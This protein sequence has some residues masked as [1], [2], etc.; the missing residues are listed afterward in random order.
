[1]IRATQPATI[2]SVILKAG[3]LTYETIRYGILSKSSE[4]RKE[5]AESSKQGGSW[6]D[7]KRSKLGKG[8]VATV[9]TMNEYAGIYP[10]CAKCNAHHP[11]SVPCLLFY[12]SPGQAGNRLTIKGNQN[13]RV[14]GNQA[15]GMAFNMKTIEARHD[16]NVVT[17]TFSVN[18]HFAII[19][20]DSGADFSS[21]S[22]DFVSL[23]NEKPSILRPSYVIGITNDRK[24]ESNMIIHGCKLELVDSLF[25]IDLI[26]F[27]HGSFD[28]I[29]G[30]DWLSNHKA[31]IV[32]HENVVRIPL[33]T[34]ESPK[35]MK[36]KK[37]DEPKLGDILIVRDFPEV[38][39]EDL[40]GLPPQ[41]Q[42][43]FHIDLVP[44]ATPITKSPYRLAP[45][46][47]QELSKQLQELQDTLRVHEA[48]IPKTAFRSRYGHFEFTVMPFGLTNAP[49]VF[50]DL[51]NPVCKPY[52]NK[53]VIVFIDDILIY[54]KSKEDHEAHLKLVLK[55]L[56]KEKLF[57]KSS[58]CEFWLQEVHF[59]RH[60]VNNNG[61]HVDPSG[62]QEEA[63]QT[64]KDN[65]RNAPIL[66][67]LD[68]PKDFVVYCDALNQGFGCVLMQRSKKALGTRLDMSTAY[69]PQ[70]DGRSER[71][72]Q[73][74]EDM[75]RACVIDFRELVQETNHKV[76]LIKERL[77]A[78]RDRQKSYADNR[79]KPLKF[80]VGDQVLLK[81]LPWKGVVHFG[82]KGK[83]ASRYVGPFEILERIGP[84][85]YR[86]RFPQEL[87]SVH[88]T[89]HVSNLK[90]C[91][92]D[93]NLHMPLEEIKVDKT[94][95]FVEEHVEIMDHEVK[96]LKRSRIPIITTRK[97]RSESCAMT[98][99]KSGTD[100][101]EQSDLH[102][103]IS[104]VATKNAS[105][106]HDSEIV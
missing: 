92:A 50:M 4:K 102:N 38:F 18:D 54:S 101:G 28:V 46:D 34:V 56:K 30:M 17:S 88:D 42:V 7:N 78:A 98:L 104:F 43:E 64:L 61:I 48:D 19:L 8:C 77:K 35:S 97:G 26:P 58:K 62:E 82:K 99:E 27:G 22:T 90:K 32:C 60:V 15:R 103:E 93:A 9:P 36:G 68:G 29:M 44:G 106:G 69:H 1:M 75:L 13:A 41:C 86:L 25:T 5:V 24:V 3:V 94:L 76:V 105:L 74:L 55:L 53:F 16:P 79:H 84:V 81:V 65:L 49:A 73:T 10:R 66:S 31:V 20:F 23:L 80:E 39:L 6:T 100:N 63:F 57:A 47:M 72:I 85:A 83:L 2:Q 52:L 12:N 67:F 87:S 11:T 70:T 14:N 91:L 45:S 95:R 21:I 59:L 37:S 33:S 96:K 71:T 51:M 40:S 89:F